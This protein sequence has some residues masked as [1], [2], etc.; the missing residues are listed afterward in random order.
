MD[1][2]LAAMLAEDLDTGFTRLVT[3]HQNRLYAAALALTGCP[4]DAEEITVDAFMR[5]HRALRRYP[6][7]RIRELRVGAWLY[8]I[9]VNAARN[10]IRGRHQATAHLDGVAEIAADGRLQPEV[11]AERAVDAAQ[12]RNHLVALPRHHREAVVLRH[13]RGMSY[14]EAADVLGRP[15]GTVKADVHRGLARLRAALVEE[16]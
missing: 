15:V 11:V 6:E 7:Q 10:H 9:T 2:P 12:L 13:V 3:S 4:G 5:A 14:A 8:R 16:S 1:K